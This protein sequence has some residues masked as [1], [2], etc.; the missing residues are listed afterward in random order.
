LKNYQKFKNILERKVYSEKAE[1]AYLSFG[2]DLSR[3]L[4]S[5]QNHKIEVNP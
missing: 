5:K 1:E 4:G 3:G 2:D